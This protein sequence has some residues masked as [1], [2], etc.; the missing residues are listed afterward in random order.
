M[1]RCDIT[2]RAAEDIKALPEYARD[3]LTAVLRGKCA[4]P[5]GEPVEWGPRH[6]RQIQLLAFAGWGIAEIRV[7]TVQDRLVL[8]RALWLPL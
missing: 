4:Q 5:F 1:Y 2:V 6:P 7:D 3:E 8:R